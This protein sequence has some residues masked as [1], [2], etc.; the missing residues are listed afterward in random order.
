MQ[1]DKRSRSQSITY[2]ILYA[3]SVLATVIGIV[4]S[5]D[6]YLNEYNSEL[7]VFEKCSTFY[8]YVILSA[9]VIV[10]CIVLQ[11]LPKLFSC[12]KKELDN[13]CIKSI[14]I[15]SFCG[16]FC[17]AY[18]VLMI[19]EKIN[20]A[21]EIDRISILI[22]ALSL[23]SAL[24]FFFQ[25]VG[26]TEKKNLVA[27][28]GLCFVVFC[29]LIIFTVHYNSSVI[30]ITSPLRICSL[31]SYISIMLF[32]LTEIRF[33]IGNVSQTMHFSMG[34]ATMFFG[35]TSSLPRLY[36]SIVKESGFGLSSQTVLLGIELFCGIYA[37]FR[38]SELLYAE[39]FCYSKNID[40][41]TEEIF[42]M[43]SDMGLE[44]ASS[45]D[46]DELTL[47]DDIKA[48]NNFYSE[49]VILIESDN[50]LPDDVGFSGGEEGKFS[51]ED[52]D[53]IENEA[54]D[55]FEGEEISPF[56][57]ESFKD[58]IQEAIEES[59]EDLEELINFEQIKNSNTENAFNNPDNDT[60][61]DAE[62]VNL[63]SVS[64]EAADD[65][66]DDDDESFERLIDELVHKESNEKKTEENNGKQK[67]F[68]IRFV[69]KM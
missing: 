23:L 50:D 12:A 33:Y 48:D 6:L 15:N 27:L 2:K 62:R 21:I 44:T 35:I 54:E 47:S 57:E 66:D 65:D 26:A 41:K 34:V 40:E 45:Q 69:K 25:M 31:L 1:N 43:I 58:S 13:S 32:I 51:V 10:F 53:F 29:I 56:E 5:F 67:K 4:F 9:I 22:S 36:L 42:E 8:A 37:A 14:F 11:F 18:P 38:L 49:D 28:L 63:D 16:I 17:L 46:S 55:D 68:K 61:A 3:I 64:A 30:L 19:Y 7:A 59:T 52:Y 20:N 60:A 24:F 39:K